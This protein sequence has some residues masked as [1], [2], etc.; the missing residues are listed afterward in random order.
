MPERMSED[1]PDTYAK[2]EYQIECQHI[3][4]CNII[5]IYIY[6]YYI[7]IEIYVICI[8]IYTS[9]WYVRNYESEYTICQGG[10]H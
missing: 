8:Y 9:R 5:L 3:Y 2:K 10:E 1:M 4:I 7:Y 6:Q